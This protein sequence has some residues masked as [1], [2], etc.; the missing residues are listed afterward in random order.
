MKRL[1]F[2]LIALALA[3]RGFAAPPKVCTQGALCW[4]LSSII[5]FEEPSDYTR[6]DS[7][8]GQRALLE[9][10]GQ[11]IGT[12]AG[13]IGTNSANFAGAST[14]YLK[15]T[16]SFGD[17]FWTIA[18]WIYPTTAGSS[19]Q[20]QALVSNDTAN[21]RGTML[22]LYNNAGTL[23]VWGQ[24]YQTDDT[25]KTVNTT[26]ALSLSTWHRVVFQVSTFSHGDGKIYL[27]VDNG[28]RL[29]TTLTNYVR[30]SAGGDIYFSTLIGKRNY[31]SSEAPYTGRMM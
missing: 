11:N 13:K 6:I 29:S 23:Q 10:A 18:V 1:L 27:T 8:S 7:Q 28:S 19:G 15:T 25:L 3:I 30:G 20:I 5:E 21:E 2:S 31:S 14:S 12:A 9:P 16:G 26:S 17:G 24:V 22:Y 4:G